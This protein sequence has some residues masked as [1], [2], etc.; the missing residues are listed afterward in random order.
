M[1]RSNK[2]SSNNGKKS[3]KINRQCKII[4]DYLDFLDKRQ[5]VK[6][7]FKKL[8]RL[9]FVNAKS[10]KYNYENLLRHILSGGYCVI[11]N[12]NGYVYDELVKMFKSS[13]RLKKGVNYGKGGLMDFQVIFQ[14]ETNDW[15]WRTFQYK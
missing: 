4:T 15:K 3:K 9:I 1:P 8:F 2:K 12:D 7:F 14:K 13:K 11:A 5:N 10:S 6:P